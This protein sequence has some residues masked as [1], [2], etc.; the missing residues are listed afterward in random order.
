MPL[1]VKKQNR[2]NNQ[3]LLRRFSKGM[4]QSGILILAKKRRFVQRV[5]SEDMKKKSALRRLEKRDEYE[6]LKK[7]GEIERKIR[8]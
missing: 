4:Q 8:R 6:K 1:E 7:L 2:E 3:S 5:K